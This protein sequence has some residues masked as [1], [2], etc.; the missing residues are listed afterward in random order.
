M[1]G[2]MQFTRREAL[3]LSLAG[4][5][6]GAAPARAEGQAVGTVFEDRDGASRPGL[7][8]VLVSNGRDV[9]A[10]DAAGR[11]ILPAPV[12]CVFFVI[13]PAGYMPQGCSTL[14]TEGY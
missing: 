10:T 12:P 2:Q 5:L 13:K 11:W 8:G 9:T 14:S 7:A 4:G 6:I 1:A 3:A